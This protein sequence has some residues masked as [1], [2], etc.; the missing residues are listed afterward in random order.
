MYTNCNE[1]AGGCGSML[2]DG[3]H[4]GAELQVS[5]G[6]TVLIRVAPTPNGLGSNF[7]SGAL[8]V[9]FDMNCIGDLNG[10]Q[11][12]NVADVLSLIA[13][14]GVCEGC[15]SDFNGDGK[16]AVDDLLVLIGAWGICE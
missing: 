11:V 14:W 12:V 9:D 1:M 5:A 16:V 13:D 6:T 4:G 7:V 10:D 3:V 2:C 15:A 8:L